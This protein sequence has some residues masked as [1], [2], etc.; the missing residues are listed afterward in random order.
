MPL[1]IEVRGSD[2]KKMIEAVELIKKRI[3]NVPGLVDL[4]D[5][6][7]RSRPELKVVINRDKASRLGLRAR[8]IASTVR[9]AFNGKKV[10]VYRD[11]TEEYDIWV[12]LDQSFRENQA[13]L[14]SLFIFTPTGELVRLSE[15]ARVETGPSYGSIRH[16][17]TDRAITITGDAYRIPGPVLVKLVQKAMQGLEIP[18]GVSSR[19]TGENEDRKETQRFIGQ[20]L[21]IAVFLILLVMIAQFNS[22]APVSYTHLTLPTILLV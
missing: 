11:G 4:T 5:D 20:A 10:S 14:A 15:I 21:V 19:F 7:D 13:D 8:E 18:E 2:Y 3:K 12:Q 22:I 17:D 6:F 1:N 16:V 9:T